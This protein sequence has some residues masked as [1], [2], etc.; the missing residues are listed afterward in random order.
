MLLLDLKLM[1]LINL[2]MIMPFMLTYFPFARD[3]RYVLGAVETFLK[4]VPAAGIFRGKIMLAV[5]GC[6]FSTEYEYF[7]YGN[8]MSNIRCCHL[9][10]REE[11]GFIL[12]YLL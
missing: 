4:A 1:G 7:L 3:S 2:Y 5:E 8:F 9:A 6:F 11:H 10:L 12:D